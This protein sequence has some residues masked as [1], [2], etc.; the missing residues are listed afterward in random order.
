MVEIRTQL[1]DAWARHSLLT[2]VVRLREPEEAHA[3]PLMRSRTDLQA[4][5]DH[6]DEAIAIVR[7]AVPETATGSPL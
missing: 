5:L 4:A 2:E 6:L 3:Q 7:H 1:V